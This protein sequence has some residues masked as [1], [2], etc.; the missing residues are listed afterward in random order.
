MFIKI[1]STQGHLEPEVMTSSRD[2]MGEV[3]YWP[4]Q[5]SDIA[6]DTI[7][8]THYYSFRMI[9]SFS[10]RD[11]ES[12]FKGARARSLPPSIRRR[13]ERK[14]ILLN[15]AEDIEELRVP[16]GNRLEILKGDR[17]GQ[18]S[19]R[20]NEQW[21]VCFVWRSGHAHYVEITDYHD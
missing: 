11:T 2:F 6:L 15:A 1:E 4:P 9:K 21:R 19:I 7:S 8:A 12:V 20:I 16:P 18:H 17:L 14:L 3:M 10:D 5:S 13:A